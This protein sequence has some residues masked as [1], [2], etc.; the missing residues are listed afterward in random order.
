MPLRRCG[1]L[2]GIRESF[3]RSS[4]DYTRNADRSPLS[5]AEPGW[6]VGLKPGIGMKKSQKIGAWTVHGS[7][8]I[9]K[10]RWIDLRADVCTT[11]TGVSISPYYVLR[12]PDWAHSVCLDDADRICVVSQYRHGAARVMMELPGGVVEA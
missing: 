12:Y 3:V 10:D 9:I 5:C 1:I 8:T 6:H 11:P 2:A 4:N 7:S